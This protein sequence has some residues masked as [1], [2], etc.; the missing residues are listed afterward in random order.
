MT[1]DLKTDVF[2]KWKIGAVSSPN[3]GA[4]HLLLFGIWTESGFSW[5]ESLNMDLKW[6]SPRLRL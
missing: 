3:T 1:A 6:V 2:S 4:G 5:S